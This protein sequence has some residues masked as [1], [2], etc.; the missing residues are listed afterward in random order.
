[1]FV[2]LAAVAA[3]NAITPPLEAADPAATDQKPVCRSDTATGSHFAKRI[4]H[5]KADWK[6][7]DAERERVGRAANDSRSGMQME[8]FAKQSY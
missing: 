4:C 2:I 6:A 3:L 8:G 5:T 7:M 1:M